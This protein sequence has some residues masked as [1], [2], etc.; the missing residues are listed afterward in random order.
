MKE[1]RINIFLAVFIILGLFFTFIFLN[2]LY[3]YYICMSALILSSIR[4]ITKI[5]ILLFI[6]YFISQSDFVRM[7]IWLYSSLCVLAHTMRM[8]IL[9]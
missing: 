9:F 8:N 1:V 5:Y 2:G 7:I 4:A 6:L 3:F